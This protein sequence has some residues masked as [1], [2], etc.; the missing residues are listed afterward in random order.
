MLSTIYKTYRFTLE[1]KIQ[2]VGGVIS[3]IMPSNGDIDSG[4]P[5]IHLRIRI[6]TLTL[7]YEFQNLLGF[8]RTAVCFMC[9]FN[10]KSNSVSTYH[11]MGYILITLLSFSTQNAYNFFNRCFLSSLPDPCQGWRACCCQLL[12]CVA[13]Q[14]VSGV[15]YSGMLTEAFFHQQLILCYW[16]LHP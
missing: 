13:V 12:H 10:W 11:C 5:R 1:Y 14:L 3:A 4:Q 7:L 8:L 9:Q 6:I 16:C 2:L 15:G